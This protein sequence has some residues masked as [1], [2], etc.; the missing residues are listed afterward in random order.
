MA[1][2]LLTEEPCRVD[3]LPVLR[4]IESFRE[5]LRGLGVRVV[6]HDG[7]VELQAAE[8]DNIRASY[9]LVRKMRA[10]VMVLGPLVARTGQAE[11]SLPGGCA[12]GVRPIDQHLK[13]LAAMGVEIDLRGGYI[14]ARAKRLKGADIFLDLVTVTGTKN[15]MMAAA[16]ADGRTRIHNAAREPE[17]VQLAEAL[18]AM[19]A[20]V[21]GVGTDI[22]EV[23]GAS[24]LKGF[25]ARV[26]P[27]RI[28][29]GTYMLAGAVTQGEVSVTGGC[30]EHVGALTQKL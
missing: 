26:I 19:G 23:V 2:C 7:S 15:L 1:A 4:D 14:H 13:G 12:I 29:T 18:T 11:V 10:S 27:D 25:N 5:L 30:P 9:D 3:N 16:L 20:E 17:V 21:C 8:L 22:V 28:E 24:T 6:A